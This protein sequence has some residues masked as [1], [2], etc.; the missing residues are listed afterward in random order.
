MSLKNAIAIGKGLGSLL[1]VD[2]SSGVLK[3]FR[4]Y[5]KI[6]VEIDITKPLKAAF[7]CKE[8]KENLF[9]S[10]SSMKDLTFTVPLVGGLATKTP[11]AG[12]L[13]RSNSLTGTPFP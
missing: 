1:E 6:L 11:V 4:S 7:P 10:V 2:E 5:L 8:Q 13:Q 12:H 3:T 9:G